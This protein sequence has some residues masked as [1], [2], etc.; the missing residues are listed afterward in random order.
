MEDLFARLILILIMP[1]YTYF[2]EECLK[3]FELFFYIKDY[4]SNPICSL[5]DSRKTNRLYAADVATQSASVRKSDSELKTIGDIAMRN[6]ERMSKDE[7]IHLY[8][9]HNS[10]KENVSETKPLPRGMSRVKKTP[11]IKWPGTNDG[12]TRRSLKK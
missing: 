10:Y 6:T 11:K 12:K 9:K 3:S 2:C 8:Q 4:N 7:K 5:C 1:T